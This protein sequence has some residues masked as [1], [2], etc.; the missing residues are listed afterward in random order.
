M[1]EPIPEFRLQQNKNTKEKRLKEKAG[2]EEV[3]EGRRKRGKKKYLRGV[4]RA[5]RE[6]KLQKEKGELEEE[7]E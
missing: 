1:F 3:E 2:E 5:K 4:R 6:Q 7:M